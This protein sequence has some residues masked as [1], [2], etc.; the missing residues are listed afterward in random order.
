MSRNK[1]IGAVEIGTSKIKVLLG[2]VLEQDSINVVGVG[3]IE[4]LGVKKGE[5]VNFKE[6][7]KQVSQ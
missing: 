7:S 4:S 1:I 6:A 3:A 2:E 5:V